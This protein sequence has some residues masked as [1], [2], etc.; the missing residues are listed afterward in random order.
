[1]E[2]ATIYDM[3]VIPPADY[4]IMEFER[5]LVKKEISRFI[6]FA[7]L[8]LNGAEARMKILSIQEKF[9]LLDM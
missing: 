4:E 1:M 6:E 3:I 7:D 8:A 9:G 5:N 2:F